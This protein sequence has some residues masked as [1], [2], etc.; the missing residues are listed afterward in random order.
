MRSAFG[1]S[2]SPINAPISRVEAPKPALYSVISGNRSRFT[3][4]IRQQ[5]AHMVRSKAIL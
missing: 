2:T 3:G 4:P 5:P 1:A